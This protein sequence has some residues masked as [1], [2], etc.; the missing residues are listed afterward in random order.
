MKN[1][2]MTYGSLK[3][4]IEYMDPNTRIILSSR[5]PSIRTAERAVPLKI[6]FL[7]IGNRFIKVNETKYEYGS[8]QDD[9]KDKCYYKVSG[10]YRYNY[11]LVCDVDEHANC[12]IECRK[13]RE[14]LHRSEE[15][16]RELMFAKRHYAVVVKNLKI[17][18]E[19]PLR[20]PRD[21]KMNIRNLEFVDNVPSNLK[22]IKPIIDESCLP[23]ENLYIFIGDN[24]SKEIDYEFIKNCKFLEYFDMVNVH[25]PQIQQ[26]RNQRVQFSMAYSFPKQEGFIDLIRNWLETDKP[27]GTC[28]EFISNRKEFLSMGILN[29]VRNQF[30]EAIVGNKCVNIP[31]KNSSLLEIS[32]ELD[33]TNS[34]WIKMAVVPIE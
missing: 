22:L 2:P 23:L 6:D 31:M 29:R 34:Y 8:Y 13:H 9:F 26:F 27:I 33:D 12:D 1:K 11:T 16:L 14:F 21:L 28:F 20:M 3:T 24:K 10:Y 7:E 30:D 19:C 4:V 17:S 18:Q 25:L 32:Y 5:I 15:S